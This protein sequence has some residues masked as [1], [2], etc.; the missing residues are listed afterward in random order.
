MLRRALRLGRDYLLSPTRAA[1]AARHDENFI[2]NL[3]LYAAFLAGNMLL[4]RLM[5]FDF[6]DKNAPFPRESLDLFYWFKVMMLWQPLFQAASIVLL[7]G[8]VVWFK[9]G[10]L[11]VRLALGVAWTAFALIINIVAYAQKGGIPKPVFAA[12]SAA[13]FALFFPLLRKAPPQDWKPVFSFMLGVNAIGLFFLVPLG[14][15]VFAGAPEAFKYL[16]AADGLWLLGAG[17]LGLRA[18]TGLRLPRAFMALLLAMFFQIALGFT[19]YLLGV[20]GSVLKAV[21]LYG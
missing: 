3:W 15:A 2:A 16:Q 17:T 6:I 1:A 13:C 21:F 9:E 11:P 8:F 18:L 4:Y 10:S 12:A 7:M 20:P 19:L 14:A 5:P